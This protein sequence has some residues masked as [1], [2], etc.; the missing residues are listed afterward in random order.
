MIPKRG[1][2]NRMAGIRIRD[3][4]GAISGMHWAEAFRRA[5]G[6]EDDLRMDSGFRRNDIVGGGKFG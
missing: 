4:N 5:M 2:V 3:G 1:F 6:L